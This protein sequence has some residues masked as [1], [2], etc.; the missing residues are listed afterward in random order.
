MYEHQEPGRCDDPPS[1]LTPE[2]ASGV[3]VMGSSFGATFP[4][5][6]RSAP[7]KGVDG[8][9]FHSDRPRVIRA[10]LMWIEYHQELRDHLKV[11]RLAG[12][13][14]IPYT[15]AL[16]LLSCLWLWA[17]SNATDGNLKS[18]SDDE[19]AHAC[20]SDGLIDGKRLRH[21][22]VK[23]GLVDTNGLIHKWQEY[24]IKYVRLARQRKAT[25]KSK[26]GTLPERSENVSGTRTVPT[27]PTVPTKEI[28]DGADAPPILLHDHANDR[29]RTFMAHLAHKLANVIGS[30]Q[31]AAVK[32][33]YGQ[34]VG[35]L[36]NHP[37]E[38]ESVS[39]EIDRLPTR[40][41]TGQVPTP[42]WC[43]KAI[44]ALVQVRTNGHLKVLTAPIGKT[45]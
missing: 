34:V 9:V 43:V 26:H 30:P 29:M 13:L 19:L 18:L 16:G 44:R 40:L 37:D 8:P 45:G 41:D 36:A 3:S 23:S 31:P 15:H 25:W 22:L 2:R 42:D 17:A 11:S 20:R 4:T 14:S 6:F 24:G 27:V 5:G 28:K 12:F 38:I 7:R 1:Q 35:Y 21:A 33:V 10:F 32:R 39:E